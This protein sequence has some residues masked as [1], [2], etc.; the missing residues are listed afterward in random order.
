MQTV[1]DIAL[2]CVLIALAVMLVSVVRCADK[3]FHS[4][5][6]DKA[7]TRREEEKTDADTEEAQRNRDFQKGVENIMSYKVNGNDG[8]APGDL[9]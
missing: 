6:L 7:E 2:L 5:F 8:L 3:I 1:V 4:G 9:R